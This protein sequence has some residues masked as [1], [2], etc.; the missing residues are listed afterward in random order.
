MGIL[1]TLMKNPQIFGDIARFA[2]D[3]PQIAKAAA[4][5]LS[6][7]DGS[8]GGNGGLAGILSAF[9][10]SGMDDL[11]SSWLGNGPNQAVS[12]EQVQSALGGDT[13]SQFAQKAGIDAGEAGAVLAGLLP[14]L[15]DKLSPDG[16]AP[17]AS[18][19]D[20]LLGGLFGRG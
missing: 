8:V 14:Q 11:V 19:L 5:L 15:V 18:G 12:P 17:Q 4:S 6:P 1:D 10:S 13:L 3:N 7:N 2:S 16:Q 9:Q 20:G